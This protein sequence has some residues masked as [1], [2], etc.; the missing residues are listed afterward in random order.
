MSDEAQPTATAT[1]FVPNYF[2]SPGQQ[3]GEVVASRTA[4]VASS[5]PELVLA[6]AFAAGFLF[7][8]LLRGRGR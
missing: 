1:E 7:A 2:S 6:G 3:K 4:Q 8:K 5:R